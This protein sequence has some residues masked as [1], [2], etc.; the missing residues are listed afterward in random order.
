MSARRKSATEPSGVAP[1]KTSDAVPR[2]RQDA[3]SVVGSA[4]ASVLPTRKSG[5]GGAVRAASSSHE[6]T[7]G[8]SATTP[9]YHS[10]SYVGRLLDKSPGFVIRQIL[11]GNLPAIKV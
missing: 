8:R 6:P 9:A 11:S 5:D 10:P 3:A 1:D 2:G 7:P 4:N